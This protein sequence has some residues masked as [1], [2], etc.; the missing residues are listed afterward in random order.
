MAV[1]SDSHLS[2]RTPE[3]VANW[4]AA[5][6]DLAAAPP[7]AVVHAGD[8]SADGPGHAGDLPF[9]RGE[10]D[11]LA[12]VPATAGVGVLP[13][14]H[15]V[16]ESPGA[17][18]EHR[19]VAPDLLDRYRDVVGPDRWV[20]DV[21][22]WRLVG[23]NAL[24]MG[25]GLADE[26]EAQWAWLARALGDG[27]HEH[28]ALFLHKPLAPP[29]DRPDPGQHHRYVPPA[30]RRRLSAV[31][32]GAGAPGGTAVRAVVS[33]HVHQYRRHDLDGVPQ[34]WAPT[35]WAVLPERIQ[36]VLGE[37]ACGVLDLSLAADGTV[38]AGLRRPPGLSQLVLGHD[39]A[40]PY[41][42]DDEPS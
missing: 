22:S 8:L 19:V 5:V 38:T 12:G 32:A 15:D 31:L 27:A 35:T 37:K 30:D 33:G 34:V 23:L 18:P 25:S 2:E 24:V 9:A 26:E 21:G 4:R 16:G 3:A 10:L 36:P 17:P 7:D 40:N 14:N 29:P 41:A 42:P 6:D 11:R 39:L 28:V 13:G 20:L 1:V